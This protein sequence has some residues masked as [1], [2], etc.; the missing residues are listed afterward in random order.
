MPSLLLLVIDWIVDAASVRVVGVLRF[1][2]QRWFVA[3]VEQLSDVFVHRLLGIRLDEECRSGKQFVQGVVDRPVTQRSRCCSLAMIAAQHRANAA[4]GLR[5]ARSV[6]RNG[7]I[8][9]NGLA[10]ATHDTS[11][12]TRTAAR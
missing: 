7:H 6:S 11:A 12:A 1:E 9:V 2:L 5:I 4:P 10:P 8:D 3:N